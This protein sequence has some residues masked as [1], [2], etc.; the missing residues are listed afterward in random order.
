MVFDLFVQVNVINDHCVPCNCAELYPRAPF[1]AA[2]L[3]LQRSLS[4]QDV[5]K[6]VTLWGQFFKCAG[7]SVL[8]ITNIFFLNRHWFFCRSICKFKLN[9]NCTCKFLPRFFSYWSGPRKFNYRSANGMELPHQ[10]Y[11][12]VP[13]KDKPSFFCQ[14]WARFLCT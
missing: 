11:H 12:T 9:T 2:Y 14:T 7:P 6:Y 13:W 10:Q 8:V 5:L 3:I 4:I 1:S